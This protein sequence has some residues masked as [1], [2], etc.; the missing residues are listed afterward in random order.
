MT[1]KIYSSPDCYS[2]VGAKK[3]DPYKIVYC[4]SGLPKG[5][6]VR[7]FKTISMMGDTDKYHFYLRK[8]YVELIDFDASDCDPYFSNKIGNRYALCDIYKMP[9][10][11]EHSVLCSDGVKRQILGRYVKIYHVKFDPSSHDW[12]RDEKNYQRDSKHESVKCNQ[13]GMQ[14]VVSKVDHRISGS[15]FQQR[16]PNAYV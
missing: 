3:G 8:S 10:Q 15:R 9:D 5:K 2:M 16:C 13:C 6:A 12:Q 4:Y 11:A 14:A 1:N 7:T